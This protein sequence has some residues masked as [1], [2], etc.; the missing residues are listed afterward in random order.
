M[1]PISQKSNARVTFRCY[2]PGD[3]RGGFHGWYDS[4]PGNIRAEIDAALEVLSRRRRPWP[5][6]IYDQLH[7]KC[8]GL[9]EVKIAV[10]KPPV[11]KRSAGATGAADTTDDETD[12]EPDHYRILAWEGPGR[13]DITL[14]DGFKKENNSDYGSHCKKA[15][16]RRDGV[17]KDGRRAQPCEF[18]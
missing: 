3:G 1:A 12:Q 17:K 13:H 16:R 18:P 6:T 10:P 15:L 11:A 4:L 7:G 14:L 2:D 9:T 8:Y 5:E